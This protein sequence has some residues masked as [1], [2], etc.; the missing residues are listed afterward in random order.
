M[1]DSGHGSIGRYQ[2]FSPSYTVQTS[3]QGTTRVFLLDHLTWQ[4]GLALKNAPED[5]RPCLSLAHSG[6]SCKVLE[7]TDSGTASAS[8][9]DCQSRDVACHENAPA[10]KARLLVKQTTHFANGSG[11]G[12]KPY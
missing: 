5:L 11:P 1:Q 3:T 12:V 8:L 10:C 2:M 9:A 6:R 4:D 7:Q